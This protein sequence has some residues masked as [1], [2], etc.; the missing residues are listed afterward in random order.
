MYKQSIQYKVSISYRGKSITI[1]L[2]EMIE[3]VDYRKQINAN[4]P[5]ILHSLDAAHLMCIVNRCTP[6]MK[7][8]YRLKLQ[9]CLGAHSNNIYYLKYLVTTEFI[10]LYTNEDFK[11]IP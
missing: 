3:K 10:Q 6:N 5:N 2:R 1:V 9:D 11:K 4:I 7:Y 8:P